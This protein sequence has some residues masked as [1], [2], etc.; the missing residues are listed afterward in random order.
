MLNDV[1]YK[2]NKLLQKS[3]PIWWQHK[4]NGFQSNQ[5]AKANNTFPLC[6]LHFSKY[7]INQKKFEQTGPACISLKGPAVRGEICT[8]TQRF[9]LLQNLYKPGNAFMFDIFVRGKNCIIYAI[10]THKNL[11]INNIVS[12]VTDFQNFILQSNWSLQMIHLNGI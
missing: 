9:S 8:L 6:T 5:K 7:T 10:F 2:R 4:S 1:L 12:Q 11:V 3:V